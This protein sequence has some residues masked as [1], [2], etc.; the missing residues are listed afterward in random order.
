MGVGN[1]HGKV[2]A[3]GAPFR[4]A[5][6]DPRD[7]VGILHLKED[8]LLQGSGSKGVPYLPPDPQTAILVRGSGIPN[9]LLPNKAFPLFWSL[10]KSI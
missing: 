9:N 6:V 4:R 3:L 1:H 8:P 5:L 7:P 2:D 10:L